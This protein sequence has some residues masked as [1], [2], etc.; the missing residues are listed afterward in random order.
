L[1]II[2]GNFAQ[3]PGPAPKALD[4]AWKTA[5]NGLSIFVNQLH[6]PKK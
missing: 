2:T 5:K 3:S 6:Q 1:D 4:E